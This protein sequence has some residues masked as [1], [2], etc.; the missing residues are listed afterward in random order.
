MSLYINRPRSMNAACLKVVND[1]GVEL[2][3]AFD[4]S[5]GAMH[6]LGRVS[7]ATYVG[8]TPVKADRPIYSDE[9][10]LRALAAHLGFEVT[11]KGTAPACDHG[12][13]RLTDEGTWKCTVC[14]SPSPDYPF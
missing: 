5:A 7:V 8:D 1:Q 13:A 14:G 12:H 11:R 2:S 10:F 4:D 3:F 9:D 6:H